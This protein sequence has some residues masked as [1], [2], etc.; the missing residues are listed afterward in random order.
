MTDNSDYETT[1]HPQQPPP[2]N[3]GFLST[4]LQHLKKYTKTSSSVGTTNSD[5]AHRNRY[6]QNKLK[7]YGLDA[8]QVRAEEEMMEMTNKKNENFFS[9]H[10]PVQ[11]PTG[12][13]R[14]FWDVASTAIILISVY[15][16]LFEFSWGLNLESANSELE[17]F[18]TFVSGE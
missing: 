11:N 8:F 9:R 3:G 2:S 6:E 10:M 18:F 14:R 7:V 4:T 5:E 16:A 12:T 15:S 1:V 17:W 13:Q